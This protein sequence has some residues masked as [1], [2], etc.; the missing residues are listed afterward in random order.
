MGST[1]RFRDDGTFTIVQ[2]TDTHWL[3]GD[4]NDLRTREL[5]LRILQEEAPDFVVVTGDM[6]E[7]NKCEQPYE[8]FRRIVS[9]L[10]EGG[11]PW[12]SVF[13][14]HDAE[15]G[16]TKE[17]LMEML[18]QSPLCLTEAGPEDISGS[19]NYT[20]P[21]SGSEGE[22]IAANLY[23]LDSGN[24]SETAAKGYNWLRHDQIGWYRE[25]S[26]AFA[27]A[28]GGVPVHS[29]AFFHIPLPEYAELWT[30][31]TC[32][33]RHFDPAFGCAKVNSG[34]FASVLEMGDISGIFVG[35]CH[36]NDFQG[37]LY[38]VRLCHGRPAG[39]NG[40]S[41]EGLLRGA[42]VI[43][44]KQGERGFETWIRQED[45]TVD[46]QLEP[47]TPEQA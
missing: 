46:R 5:V 3:N 38:G 33:G 41:R 1:L 34:F 11:I 37:D 27:E 8:S 43:R 40:Y 17:R 20:L 39:Y 30:R 35:H 7:A 19:G 18:R 15:N 32:F 9:V 2:I 25:Q 12:A 42:R 4:E 14:N 13:G 29:L 31:R 36:G 16:V 23:F 6:I 24:K 47:H 22:A 44:L 45:G 26:R 21:L 28:N 10:D